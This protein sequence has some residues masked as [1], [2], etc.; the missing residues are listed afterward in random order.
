[1][2]NWQYFFC[3]I[4]LEQHFLKN[5]QSYTEDYLGLVKCLECLHAANSSSHRRCSVKKGIFR[6][7]AKFKEKH[8]CQS[9]FF[10]KFDVLDVQLY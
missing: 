1:M 5:N 10:N 8:L 3:Q 7:F 6:N 9:L 2:V 4:Y